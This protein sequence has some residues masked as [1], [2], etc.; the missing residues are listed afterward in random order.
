MAVIIGNPQIAEAPDPGPLRYGLFRA[1]TITEDLGP[2]EIASGFQIPAEDC[3]VARLYD[4]Q[5]APGDAIA[6]TF[7]E[8]LTYMEALPYWVYSTRQCGMLG[9]SAQ[10]HARSVRRRFAGAEQGQVETALWIGG[11]G[12][13]PV[14]TTVAGV[15]TVVA[16]S[17][18]AG[19]AIAALEESFYGDYGYVG[20]IHINTRAYA[21]ARYA[22][23]VTMADS[24]VTSAGTLVTPIG[25]RWSF[26][27][28][29]GVN[30]PANV[31][32]SAGFVWA[33]MTPPVVIRRSE[34]IS[35][36][37]DVRSV[38]DRAANQFMGLA[39][40][41]YA[42]TWTCDVVHAVQVPVAAPATAADVGLP[43]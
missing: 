24:A 37:A 11:G 38:M 14:L 34:I 20:T 12:A 25:S 22:G 6:K 29:Y 30:G 10:E 40:R 5:C 33:F 16:G 19:A 7:D 28:G 31:A 23:L 2:R 39:E 13:S 8:G 9:R 26:G 3:G 1:A 4:A 36:D 15:T 41:V 27:A 18:G 17:A 42:H 21:A 35:Q 43:V 32:P